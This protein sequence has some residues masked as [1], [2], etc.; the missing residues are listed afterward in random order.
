MDKVQFLSIELGCKCNLGRIHTACP[1]L[2][3]ERYAHLDT[4]RTLNDGMIIRLATRFYREFGFT[5]LVAWHYYNEPLMEMDRMFYLMD[6]IKSAVP[7]ARFCLWT[8]GTLIPADC[9]R[10]A[11]FEQIHVT[12]YQ[13]A[14]PKN[15]DAL[16]R[17]RSNVQVHH[18]GLDK[19]LR[20]LVNV[21]DSPCLRPFTEFVVDNFGNVH[22]CCYDWRGLASPGNIFRDGVKSCVARFQAI[23]EAV[24]LDKMSPDAPEACLRCGFKTAV[25]T[26]FDLPSRNR[27]LAWRD[28]AIIARSRSSGSKPAVVFVFYRGPNSTMPVQRLIDHFEWNHEYYMESGVKVFVVTDRLYPVPDY[29]ECLVYAEPMP[30]RNGK[31]IFSLTRTKNFGVRYALAAGFSPIIVTDPDMSYTPECWRQLLTVNNRQASVPLYWMAPDFKL[32][33]SRCTVYPVTEKHVAS[34]RCSHQDRGATGTVSMT[35][36]NW[37]K[38]QWDERCV[39]YGADDGIILASIRKAGMQVLGRPGTPTEVPIYHIA[40]DASKPQVNFSGRWFVRQD[41]WDPEFNPVNFTENRRYF[42]S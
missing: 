39:G 22:L 23:R 3:S 34:C 20:G 9:S 24:V 31:P 18:N 11:A 7:T 19:R 14:P 16:R 29:A 6:L 32:R 36:D 37:R 41:T 26:S 35:A 5:G 2:S 40:H 4:S 38:V 21:S 30:V 33:Q 13:E 25:I 28:R 27:G 8:N 17:V 12:S 1:N 15:L 42:Q 10:F